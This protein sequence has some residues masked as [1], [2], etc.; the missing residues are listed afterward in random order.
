MARVRARD[1]VGFI[2]QNLHCETRVHCLTSVCFHPPCFTFT[3]CFRYA[4]I[5]TGWNAVLSDPRN[6]CTDRLSHALY[7]LSWSSR[8]RL[9]ALAFSNTFIYSTY[10]FTTVHD[11]SAWWHKRWSRSSVYFEGTANLH[12]Y[13]SCT[14]TAQL[15]SSKVPFIQCCPMKRYTKIFTKLWGVYSFMWDTVYIYIYIYNSDLHVR[16]KWYTIDQFE[17]REGQLPLEYWHETV[18]SQ[19][20][21]CDWR[22]KRASH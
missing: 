20:S 13:T 7:V 5:Y 1:A 19:T 18:M 2:A 15:Y 6:S 14:L 17:S 10:I 22:S 4:F 9:N 21:H 11:T 12:C 16:Q 3:L 8:L